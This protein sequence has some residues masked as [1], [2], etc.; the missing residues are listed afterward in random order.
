MSTERKGT[1]IIVG[2]FLLIGFSFIAVMVVMFGRSGMGTGGAYDIT[3]DFPNAS[4]IVQGSDVLLAGARI[5]TVAEKPAAPV[6][7]GNR[8]QVA[9]KLSIRSDVRIPKA[10]TFVVGSS[11]L[12]GDRYVDVHL[13]T[14]F[15]PTD[16]IE[17]GSRITGTQPG[18][19]FEQLTSKGGEVM[20]QVSKEMAKISEMLTRINDGLLHQENLKNLEETFANLKA[21]TENF[22]TTTAH[23]DDLMKKSG[24]VM[25]AAKG[26]MTT[27]D[28]A[29][30]DLRLAIA[31]LRKT[32]D[33]ATKTVEASR[34]LL[35]KASEGDGAIGT[36]LNDKK[37]AEDL[38]ALI[39]NLRRSGVLFY[40]NRPI[41]PAAT[42]ARRGR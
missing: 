41:E 40:K 38:R 31:D 10:G 27:A 19:G 8:F 26:T 42:P 5:G 28:S 6:L 35:K 14:T 32:A 15:D 23:L 12:L 18:G 21:S 36:L 16:M 13:P 37:V 7:V 9:V 39:A 29:A 3:V 33:S 34:L 22:K 1:E 11:G 25:D 20:D 30:A 4:G 2:L 24:E 17:P